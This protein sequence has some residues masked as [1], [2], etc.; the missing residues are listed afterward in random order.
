MTLRIMLVGLVASLGFEP[1]SSPDLSRWAD[2]SVAWVRAKAFELSG[3]VIE[4]N[5][6]PV[7]SSGRQQIVQ[8]EEGPAANDADAAFESA[9]AAMTA[10][11]VADLRDVARRDEAEAILAAVEVAPTGLPE[12]EEVVSVV[13]TEDAVPAKAEA[14]S[15][16]TEVETSEPETVEPREEFDRVSKAVDLTREAINA[17]AS[18]MQ[19]P[20][21]ESQ[22]TR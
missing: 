12:G 4:S 6:D 2:A 7:E 21:E 14:R 10:E 19:S 11:I 5:I 18:L 3:P 9:S 16:A 20:A 22:P 13:I 1:S 17:W 8:I 15:E